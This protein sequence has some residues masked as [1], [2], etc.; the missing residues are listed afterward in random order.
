MKFNHVSGELPKKSRISDMVIIGDNTYYKATIKKEPV[1]FVINWKTGK[2]SIIPVDIK[3]YKRKKTSVQNLQAMEQSDEVI[4]NVVGIDSRKKS[5]LFV[6]RFN[7]EGKKVGQ[8]NLTKDVEEN[9]SD[10][11]SYKLDDNKYLYTGTYSENKVL[12]SQGLFF[13]QAT[14]NDLDYLNLYNFLDLKEFL[15]YL[16]EKKQERIDRKKKRK[17]KR[18]KELKINYRIADHDIIELEDGFLFIGEAYYPTYSSQSYT[19]YTTINGVSTPTT[20][21]RRIFDGYQYTHAV[22]TKYNKQGDLLWDRNFEL[23]QTHKPYYLKRFIKVAE[24]DAQGIKL[25]YSSRNKI[26]SKY[27][28]Y[29][30]EI[31]EDQ[32]SEEIETGKDGDKTKWTNSNLSYWYDDYFLSYGSQ[33]IKNKKDKSVKRKRRVMFINKVRY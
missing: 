20:Q 3:G 11:S 16:P 24:T 1:L 26:A 30:G 6:L 18:G 25:A 23:F 2:N 7:A 29:N 32:E 9:I 33:K 19:T 8:F 12:M 28:D 21:Y 13:S 14:N 17:A 22:I 10:L 5:N 31:L 15:S 27:I 4:L